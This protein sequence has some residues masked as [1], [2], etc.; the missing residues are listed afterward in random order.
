MN[1]T[2]QQAD[3]GSLWNTYRALIQLRQANPALSSGDYYAVQADQPAV[4]S[5]LR[6]SPNQAILLVANLG[7]ERYSPAWV[8]PLKKG[9]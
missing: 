9:H 2:A 5:A 1:V 7:L 3:A 8:L 4:Y 6:V